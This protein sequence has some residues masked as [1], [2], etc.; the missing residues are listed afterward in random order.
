[1]YVTPKDENDTG[2]VVLQ[3]RVLIPKTSVATGAEKVAVVLTEA[4]FVAE[5]VTEFGHVMAGGAV[6]TTA[7]ERF[8]PVMT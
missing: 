1:M 5:T 8:P 4:P 3:L 6:S 7:K 2:L